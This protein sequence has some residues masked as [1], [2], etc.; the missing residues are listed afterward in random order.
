MVDDM[1]VIHVLMDVS[2]E[3]T[4]RVWTNEWGNDTGAIMHC[5][6]GNLSSSMSLWMDD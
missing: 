2:G 4:G 1:E 5:N 6:V 3:G